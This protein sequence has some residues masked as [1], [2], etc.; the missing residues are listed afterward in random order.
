MMYKPYYS[1][2]LLISSIFY[3]HCALIDFIITTYG[4]AY[5]GNQFFQIELNSFICFLVKLGIPPIH[6]VIIPFTVVCLS[7]YFRKIANK[8]NTYLI[9]SDRV[10]LSMGFT[11]CFIIPLGILHLQGFSSWFYHGYF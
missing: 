8:I 4:Y 1:D 11:I 7:C 6:M 10:I 5:Y 9:I 3:F 2:I